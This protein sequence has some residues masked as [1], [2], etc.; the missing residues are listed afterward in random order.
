MDKIYRPNVAGILQRPDDGRIFVGERCDVAGA[1]QFP[2]GGVD[3]GETA[4]EAFFREMEE[5]IGLKPS[6]YKVLGSRDGYRYKF[7]KGR[8]KRGKYL[9]Q[10]QTYFHCEFT[11]DESAIRLD[12]HDQEFAAYKWIDPSKFDFSVVPDFKLK[13]YRAVML[14]FF[15]VT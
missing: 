2:Q 5:E 6:D 8:P 1:W 11:G 9:G 4:E 3:K 15:G 12:A 14:D 13:V 7:P 10:E